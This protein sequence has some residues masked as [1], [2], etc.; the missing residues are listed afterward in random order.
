MNKS[1]VD[2]HPMNFPHLR[3][4]ELCPGPS[5]LA[6]GLCLGGGHGLAGHAVHALPQPVGLA[7]AGLPQPEG[8]VLAA[9]RVKLPVCGKLEYKWARHAILSQTRRESD[10]VHGS[11]VTFE[12][13]NLDPSLVIELVELEVLASAHKDLLVLVQRGGV[14]RAGDIHLLELLKPGIV[15]I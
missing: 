2:N 8:A 3:D 12:V 6:D 5:P 7:H 1:R 10:A 15:N 13:F 14:C 9:A 4:V 11:E